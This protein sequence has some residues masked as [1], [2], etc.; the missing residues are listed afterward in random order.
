[1]VVLDFGFQ[2]LFQQDAVGGLAIVLG[3]ETL[4]IGDTFYRATLRAMG[5]C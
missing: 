3:F 5:I 1:M 4:I 2:I